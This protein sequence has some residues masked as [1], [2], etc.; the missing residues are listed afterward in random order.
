MNPRTQPAATRPCRLPGCPRRVPL[1]M[2]MC[3]P[4]WR[5]VPRPIKD[6]I[7][8]T[9]SNGAGLFSPFYQDAVRRAVEAVQAR[10]DAP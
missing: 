9:W 3:R 4:H 5:Q 6:L 10:G 1:H 2:L 7:W 8:A